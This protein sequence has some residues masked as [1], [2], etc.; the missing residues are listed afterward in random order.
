[1][2]KKKKK[3]K[4]KQKARSAYRTAK[5]REKPKQ[6][7]MG[8]KAWLGKQTDRREAHGLNASGNGNETQVE[9]MRVGQ[10]ITEKG[11]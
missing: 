2:A 3:T 6:D 9:T 7:H 4:T 1:M 10:P 5:Q 8:I 11:R